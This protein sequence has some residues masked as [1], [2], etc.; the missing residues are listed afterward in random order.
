MR[1]GRSRGQPCLVRRR[2]AG[3]GPGTAM[4]RG[5]ARPPVLHRH[6]PVADEDRA[7]P[8]DRRDPGRHG[9]HRRFRALER[10]RP[11]P[12]PRGRFRRSRLDHPAVR[13]LL[14]IL[15]PIAEA[16]L[17][18]NEAADAAMS[19]PGLDWDEDLPE[20]PDLDGPVFLLGACALVDAFWAV[21][22][23]DLLGD[24]LGVLLPGPPADRLTVRPS[25][26]LARRIVEAPGVSAL[27]PWPQCP[28][29]STIDS[30]SGWSRRRSRRPTPG[31]ASGSCGCAPGQARRDEDRGDFDAFLDNKAAY[32]R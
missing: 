1:R 16:E 19:R 32:R 15:A 25:G 23:D 20:F 28:R 27:R 13:R 10:R 18:Y 8:G 31:S 30:S 21:V 2:R 6:P 22:G 29:V 5:L 14:E 11:S 7:L 17:A 3:P 24:V 12:D 4:G 26:P 9:D